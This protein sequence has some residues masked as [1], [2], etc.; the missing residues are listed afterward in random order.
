MP[1]QNRTWETEV[2]ETALAAVYAPV[3][4]RAV[5][6]ATTGT[7]IIIGEN[8]PYPTVISS[9]REARRFYHLGRMLRQALTPQK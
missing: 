8:V 3:P 4:V 1:R 6:D 5:N 7:S 9:E 2:W